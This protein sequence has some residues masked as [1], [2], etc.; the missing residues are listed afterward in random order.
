MSCLVLVSC[1][2]YEG[3]RLSS[4]TEKDLGV[5]FSVQPILLRSESY[6]WAEEGGDRALLQL[7]A[8]DCVQ[9]GKRLDEE[10]PILG[11]ESSRMFA[12]LGV[13]PGH[14]RRRFE[15]NE[16]GDTREYELDES[17]CVLFRQAH[18]E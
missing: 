10:A 11:P 18:F 14:I 5:H 4:Q 8:V 3:R 13:T 17:S 12:A 6:G 16:Q 2:H 9:V 15:M 1:G 7:E